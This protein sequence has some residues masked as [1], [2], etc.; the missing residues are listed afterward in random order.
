MNRTTYDSKTPWESIVG[1]SRAV[2]VG[3]IIAV[4]G[5]TATLPNGGSLRSA[6]AYTQ[7]KQAIENIK[8]A[9]EA[10]GG[11]LSDVIRTRI[12]VVDIV[13]DWQ[14]VGH[15]HSEYLGVTRP[16]TS[17]VEV[18]RL[19]EDWMLVEIEADAVLSDKI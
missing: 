16:A 10:L 7:T 12:F 2:R 15:A 3:N 6:D 5:T 13:R 4:T 9:L 18:R 1:Y 14:Q 19:L 8:I 17:M 11:S